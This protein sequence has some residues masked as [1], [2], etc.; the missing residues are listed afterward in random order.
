MH[1]RAAVAALFLFENWFILNQDFVTVLFMGNRALRK[2]LGSMVG[3]FYEGSKRAVLPYFRANRLRG[4]IEQASL[5]VGDVIHDC[6]GW[7][8]RIAKIE[9]MWRFGWKSRTSYLHSFDILFEDGG[10]RCECSLFIEPARSVEN[11]EKYWKSWI[12]YQREQNLGWA[13]G[14]YYDEILR[15]LENGLP[16]CDNH[17]I[18]LPELRSMRYEK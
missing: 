18:E 2:Q 8:H 13:D 1:K 7:N 16:I 4:L 12:L 11:T 17:G 14:K 3:T 9:P 5:N 10:C 15:R 6:S